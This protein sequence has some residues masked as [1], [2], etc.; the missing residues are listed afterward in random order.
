MKISSKLALFAV[1]AAGACADIPMPTGGD[2]PGIGTGT[3][4]DVPQA[5]RDIAAPFQDLSTVVF[6]EEDNCYWY[7]H[8]GPV[9]T[10]LLPLR[11][12]RGNAICA[13]APA[14]PV[15]APATPAAA[16]TAAAT[17]A[18]PQVGTLAMLSP[19]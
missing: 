4:T 19:R 9:E 5:V 10:T 1:I 2:M 13:E 6:L 16:T 15:A 8:R 3:N 7:Q 17:T 12:V 14:T 11:T 18:F